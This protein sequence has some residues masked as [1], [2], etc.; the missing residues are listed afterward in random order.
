[1]DTIATSQIVTIESKT[2]T[3]KEPSKFHPN[4]KPIRDGLNRPQRNDNPFYEHIFPDSSLGKVLHGS[5]R[6]YLIKQEHRIGWARK[7]ACDDPILLAHPNETV[8]SHQW[9]VVWL[10][11]TIS[12][13]SEFKDE[14]PNF[15]LAKALEMASIHDL[16]EL[17]TGDIT[18]VDGVSQAEKHRREAEAMKSILNCYPENVGT[19]LHNVYTSYEHRQCPESKFVKDCDKL[20]FILNAFLLERQGF[21]NFTEF[22]ANCLKDPFSTKIA[23]ELAN[24]LVTTRNGLAEKGLLYR[25]S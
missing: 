14:L 10:I 4:G 6:A 11:M 17:E 12:R 20:D 25:K 16:A 8:A 1:M 15:D 22:Y 24:L 13:M 23:Q 21:T 18:P 19:S 7:S 5:V 9:G 2:S 3:N